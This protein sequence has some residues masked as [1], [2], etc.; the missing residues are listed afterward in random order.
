MKEFPEDYGISVSDLPDI[1][2]ED[3]SFTHVAFVHS[4]T[5]TGKKNRKRTTLLEEKKQRTKK[6]KIK[7]Q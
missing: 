5:T 7:N 4:E 6:T 1:L 2:K 3:D